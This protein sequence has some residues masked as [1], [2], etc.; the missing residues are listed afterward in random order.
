MARY[1]IA[2]IALFVVFSVGLN[3][4][5]HGILHTTYPTVVVTNNE[6]KN[7]AP[8]TVGVPV[9]V[10][11]QEEHIVEKIVDNKPVET[12]QSIVDDK[13]LHAVDKILDNILVTS[14]VS[15]M[16]EEF[17]LGT[18]KEKNGPILQYIVSGKKLPIVLLT[19]NRPELL[20]ST[21]ESLLKVKGVVSENLL[22]IQDGIMEEVANIVKQ[23][24]LQ[25]IQNTNG[26]RL[27]AGHIDG[28][29]RIAQHY[30]FALTAAFDHFKLAPAIIVVEDDLLFAPDFLDYFEKVS[31]IIE[32]D[33]SVF[34]ISAWNDNGFK[35]RIGNPH[36]LHRTEFFPGLGW[37]LPRELYKKELESKWPSEHWDHWLRSAQ[38]HKNRAV[39]YPQVPRTYH[40]GIKGT[41]MN[42]D[43]HN[44]YFKDIGTN[45]DPTVSWEPIQFYAQ[46]AQIYMT[47][48]YY[49][50][51]RYSVYAAI[52]AETRKA[53]H[54]VTSIQDLLAQTDQL[55]C[56]WINV[57]T[58]P[59]PYRPPDFEPIA[60]FFGIW[61][62]YQ[63]GSFENV[64]EF[65]WE[66]NYVHMVNIYNYEDGEVYKPVTVP[67][68]PARDFDTNLLAE[69]R[70][71]SLNLKTFAAAETNQNC[72]D[73]CK[74][75]GLVCDAAALPSINTCDALNEA[76][77][78]KS[79]THSNGYEQPAIVVDVSKSNHGQCLI[80]SNPSW[81]ASCSAKHA[82][83]KRLCV[84]K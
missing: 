39:V 74:S 37:L 53:C 68:I 18:E 49:I 34:V 2:I 42:L 50:F 46:M 15:D 12:P 75:H 19:C 64:H 81:S 55:L 76:F 33:D 62:E 22:V 52:K 82:S 10:V 63:R 38:I 5:F 66:T 16:V 47:V 69:K 13:P 65:Y 43:T 8:E 83:T 1:C 61:H 20:K 21:L 27:R 7:E 3:L 45:A 73:V 40:N 70:R 36:K 32:K 79:C 25:L 30:K 67:A 58:A 60:K 14:M 57:N 59:N 31:P 9:T 6:V 77:P 26:I 54:H 29:A 80:T 28:A 11:K 78:C 84:C 41:F 71:K 23:N 17:V 56:L 4:G 24:D 35:E 72:D 51:S 44:R 48:P